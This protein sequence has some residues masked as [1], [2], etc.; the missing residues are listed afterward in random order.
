MTA[1]YWI[2]LYHETLHDPKMGRL[3]DHLYRR[4]IEIF[5]LAGEYDR[6]GLLPPLDDMAWTLRT[7]PDALAQD[8]HALA[9]V[10][11]TH[12][13]EDGWVV[14]HFAARQDADNSAE[15][16][17]QLRKRKQHATYSGDA[18]VTNRNADIDIDKDKSRGEREFERPPSPPPTRVYR[19]TQAVVMYRDVFHVEP[20]EGQAAKMTAAVLNFEIWGK[21]LEHWNMHG[22][23][24]NNIPGML[25]LYKRGGVCNACA[26]VV[27]GKNGKREMTDEEKIAERERLYPTYHAG[28]E[29]VKGIR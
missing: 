27:P 28:D 20:N 24:A 18:A 22:W 5:L 10:D 1:K 19:N 7:D 15:R 6:G 2:K 26:A 9:D 13:T 17:R 8:L 4:C 25:D 16:M 11:I 12:W 3:S 21:T 29:I 14:T 23:K